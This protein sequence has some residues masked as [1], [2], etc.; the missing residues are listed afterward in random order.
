M[1]VGTGFSNQS[2]SY[3]AGRAVAEQALQAGGIDSAELIFAFCSSRTDP[4]LFLKGLQAVA[5]EQVPV[6]GGSA[7]GVITNSELSYT[8]HPCGA[9]AIQ[10]GA[11][12]CRIA[13]AN[14]LHRGE[15]LSGRR[16]AEQLRA[17]PDDQAMVVF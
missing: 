4:T 17:G 10:A 2:D 7:I 12:F 6:I 9:L 3:G 8:G 16:L 5:G 14:E 11:P 15:T 1:K 13:A